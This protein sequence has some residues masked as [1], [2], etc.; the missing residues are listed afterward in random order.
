MAALDHDHSLPAKPDDARRER[1]DLGLVYLI[2]IYKLFKAVVMLV[3]GLAVLHLVHHNVAETVARWA[4]RWHLDPS[5]LIVRSVLR[6]LAHVNDRGLRWTGFTALAYMV[7]Y[8]VQ[9]V[10]LMKDRRWAEW[11][12]V[13]A[14]LGLVPFESYEMVRHPSWMLAVVLVGNLAIVAFMYHRLREK[15]AAERQHAREAPPPA[16]PHAGSAGADAT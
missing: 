5:H 11:L 16:A 9:G 2:G 3:I 8:T 4:R 15:A 6:R 1:R 13:I 10:G 7:L 12:T 14:G